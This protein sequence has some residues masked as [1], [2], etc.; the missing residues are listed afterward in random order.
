MA[1]KNLLGKLMKMQ[2]RKDLEHFFEEDDLFRNHFYFNSLPTDVVECQLHIKS[3]MVLAGLPYFFS[4]FEFLGAKNLGEEFMQ[5]FEG[6][7]V[8][9]TFG[10]LKFSLPFN[11]ALTGERLAL[12]LLTHASGIATRTF[13]YTKKASEFAISVL[14]T[15][16]TTP[17]LKSLEKYAVLVGGGSNHRF[18]QTD[19][20]MVKDNHKNFFGG[21]K[22]ALDFFNNQRGFYKP[23][24]LEV[25]NLEELK[26]A[27]ELKVVHI[28]LD[29]FSPE[30]IKLAVD[31]KPGHMTYEVSGGIT[32]DNLEE[33]LINGIDAISTSA[34]TRNPA[35][36]DL[37]LKMR[38][39]NEL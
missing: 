15:R 26:E 27:I 17:G 32:Q 19:V 9:E 39:I 16:K 2:F 21:V 11:I 8:D 7:K 1:L 10:P 14:D 30:M 25:H 4:V 29:N 5:N 12:N 3:P 23:L 35:R 28:M 38:R 6:K 36:V 31:I 33:F 18:A 22:A 13:E 20:W 24:V 34:L 37:S